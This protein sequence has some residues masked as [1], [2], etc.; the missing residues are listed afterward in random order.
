MLS[1]TL[2]VILIVSAVAIGGGF[3]TYAVGIPSSPCLGVKAV[4]RNFTIV[5]DQN[6]YNNSIV[7][8][9]QGK[10][11]PTIQWPVINVNLCDMVVIRIVNIDTQTHGFAV[12]Y[13]AARGTEIPGSQSQVIKFQVTRTGMFRMYCIV[14]CTAHNFMQYGTLNVS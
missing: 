3:A 13:Y 1:R 7:Y 10:A 11:W 6:G 14:V 4:T 5:A 12:S 2:V 9:Q 8:Y